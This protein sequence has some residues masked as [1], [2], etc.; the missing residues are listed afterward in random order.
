MSDRLPQF[1]VIPR[2]FLQICTRTFNLSWQDEVMRV[3]CWLQLAGG[4]LRWFADLLL[5]PL[6]GP[7]GFLGLFCGQGIAAVASPLTLS[8]SGAKMNPQQWKQS[9][10]S[11]I[12]ISMKEKVQVE[13]LISKARPISLECTKDHEHSSCFRRCLVWKTRAWGQFPCFGQ[14]AYRDGNQVQLDPAC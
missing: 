7:L 11:R 1:Q 3:A 14:L 8:S 4:A 9:L 6:S 10:L 2:F 13:S 12:F 5:R